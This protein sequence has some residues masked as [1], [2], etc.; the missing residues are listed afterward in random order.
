MSYVRN[1]TIHLL[2]LIWLTFVS[3]FV[4]LYITKQACMR[5]VFYRPIYGTVPRAYNG[6]LCV[7]LSNKRRVNWSVVVKSSNQVNKS[8]IYK[9]AWYSFFTFST[10]ALC[11]KLHSFRSF[12]KL[13]HFFVALLLFPCICPQ[14]FMKYLD[15]F[16]FFSLV[17][18]IPKLT[19]LH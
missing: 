17:L 12:Q 10:H 4:Y 1:C 8:W 3:D 16:Y 5:H 9:E 19:S 6:T 13:R 14:K 18:K 15:V 11:R 2:F 7:F